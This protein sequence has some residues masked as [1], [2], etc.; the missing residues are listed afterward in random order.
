M[1]VYVDDMYKTQLGEFRGMKM[2]HMAADTHE[3]LIEMAKKIGLNLKWIQKEGTS[4]EHFDVALGK[5]RL[6]VQCGAIET[7][8]MELCQ[9]AWSGYK[10]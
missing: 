4:H 9:R 7:T 2:S 6:A 1:S 10:K 8:M 3:E 5:R